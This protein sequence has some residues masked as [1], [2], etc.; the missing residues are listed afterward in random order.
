MLAREIA[1]KLG[2]KTPVCLHNPLLPGLQDTTIQGTFDEDEKINKGITSK[3]SK[4]V[5]KGAIWVND[6]PADI[7]EKY[8]EAFCPPKAV[9]GNPVLDHVRMV[10]FP[11]LGKFEVTRPAK[12]GGDV[13]FWSFEELANTYSEGIL[14]PADLK[15]GAA[16][17]M[18]GLL[19]PV[20]DYFEK[21][22]ENLE[23]M[24]KLRVTR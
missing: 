16:E 19:K 15:A 14:H 2:F 10:V 4:S 1:P 9:D 8:K 12:F 11:H 7:R 24:K 13:T 20:R 5:A 6:E 18:I 21:K 23:K 22:P 17:A 3:M